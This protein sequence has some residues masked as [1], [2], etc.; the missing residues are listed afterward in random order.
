MKVALVL[1]DTLDK[2]D[3]V[4]QYVLTLGR[5]LTKS[6]HEVYYLV[7]DTNRTD[8]ANVISLGRFLST[9]FNGNSVRTPIPNISSFRQ[10]VR[11]IDPDVIHVQM[12]YSPFLG[13]RVIT[14]A[15]RSAAIVGTFH[16]LPVSRSRNHLNKGLGLLLRPTLRRFD[17]VMAVSTPAASFAKSAYGLTCTVVPNPVDL[18]HFRSAQ[19]VDRRDIIFLGRLVERKGVLDLVRAY[20]GLP[21][22]IAKAS[23]LVIGGAGPLLTHAKHLVSSARQVEFKGFIDESAKP[24]FLASADLAVFPATGGESFGI[25]LLEAMAAGATVLAA[26]NPGYK[27]VLKD[28]PDALFE[29]ADIAGLTALLTRFLTDPELNA[30]VRRQEIST[31]GSYDIIAVGK[32]ILSVYEQAR[33]TK[34]H[35]ASK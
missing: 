11:D 9:K 35:T 27:S 7:A 17:K 34:A 8:L 15:P 23:R 2:P 16:I 24:A 28:I 33:L 30:R 6:G 10:I 4:Q 19:N 5:W 31:V 22:Q 32:Q 20:N 14:A 29:P 25:V 3:G 12:P 13:G 1:D 26:S 18:D 21:D